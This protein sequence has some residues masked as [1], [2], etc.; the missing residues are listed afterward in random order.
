MPD[1]KGI[2]QAMQQ[3]LK[4]VGIRAKL[5]TYEFATY[6]EKLGTGEHSMALYGGTDVGVDPDFRLNYWFNSAAAT[7]TAATNVSF[8][9]NPEVD[10]L[11]LQ[12]RRSV[13]PDRRRDLYHRVQEKLHEDVPVVPL[14]Y[15]R[16]PIGLQEQVEGYKI[17]YGGDR[18]NTVR[19]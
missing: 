2:A 1:G 6:L 16:P 9:E 17:T 8:Y 4:E 12:A 3:D 19:L 15:V 18:L 5:V 10:R 14:A 13:D 7:E 11:L